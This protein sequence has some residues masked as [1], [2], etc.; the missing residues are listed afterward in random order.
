MKQENNKPVEGFY[1]TGNT[2]PHK[3]HRSIFAV[4]IMVAIFLGGILSVLGIL[5]VQL[6]HRVLNRSPEEYIFQVEKPAD[7]LQN[8][9]PI[10]R[11]LDRL[12]VQI[13]LNQAPPAV[14]NIPQEGGLSL[15]DI[16]SQNISSV[17]SVTGAAGNG[18]GM[19]ITECGYILTNHHLLIG[20]Q[21]AQVQ[22]RD[23]SS[24]VGRVVGSDPVSDLAVLDVEASGLPPVTFG[25]D[26]LLQVGDSVVAIGD[27]LGPALGG[28]M[29]GGFIAA[30]NRDLELDGRTIHLLQTNAALSDGN[31]GGPLLN[32]YGQVI[33]IGAGQ[34]GH[35]ITGTP[36]EGIGFAIPSSTVKEV[37]DQLLLQ[38]FV[39]G[40]AGL[41]CRLET[42]SAF[43]QL[44]YH[45]P[46]GLFITSVDRRD[47]P[48]QPGDILLRFA[49]HR[50]GDTATLEQYLDQYEVGDSV[51]VTIYRDGVQLEYMLTLEEEN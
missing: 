19:V 26:E 1:Q 43:D 13:Q 32:C 3:S 18:T 10:L 7:N 17:V 30:I 49:G 6:F 2:D 5:N 11:E 48:V 35:T 25:S 37:V 42:V 23:G 36:V 24:Q 47:L 14:A 41:G 27:P 29:S 40:R 22:F 15:Q 21:T 38:G 45:V 50:V 34:L 20:S 9:Q 28:T 44:Y 51:S 12:P 46:A 31:S 39:S 8:T 4:L 16:Y 33:G